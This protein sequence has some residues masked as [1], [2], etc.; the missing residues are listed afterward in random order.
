MTGRATAK[1]QLPP[2]E[3]PTER[4]LDLAEQDLMQAAL[5]P[6]HDPKV[7]ELI[8]GIKK[9]LE[10]I[11][12]GESDDTLLRA[13][14]DAQALEKARSLV[15]SFRQFIEDN[16]AE[17]DAL[18][19]LYSRPYRAGLRYRHVKELAAAIQRPPVGTTPERLWGAF[20]AVEGKGDRSNLPERPEGCFAQIGPVPFSRSGGSKLVDLVALVRHAI[21]PAQPLVPFVAT[22]EER[23]QRW[24]ADQEAAGGSFT[25]EQRQWLDAIKDHIANSAVMEQEDF[26]NVPFNTMGGLGRAYDLFGDQLGEILADLNVRLA[27]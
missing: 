2:E 11:L 10:Q 4:H 9:S 6:F 20:E 22:V 25:P 5:R 19:V 1:F 7:R 13:G 17:L 8:L 12:D 15:T 18:Q 14:F 26:D 21:D 3:V 27:A 23:Y 16:R 24:L